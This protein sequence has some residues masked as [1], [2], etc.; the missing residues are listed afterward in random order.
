MKRGRER[1]KMTL[2]VVK[3]NMLIKEVSNSQRICF[4]KIRTVGKNAC[5]QPWLV[6]VDP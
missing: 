2:L 6:N 5:D 3:K 1:P 4:K